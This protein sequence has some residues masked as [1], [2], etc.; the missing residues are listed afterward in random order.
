MS[1]YVNALAGQVDKW[2]GV[3]AATIILALASA[4]GFI[5]AARIQQQKKRKSR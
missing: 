5:A 2:P 1:L 3:I 4:I